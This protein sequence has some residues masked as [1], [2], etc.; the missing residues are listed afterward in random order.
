MSLKRSSFASLVVLMFLISVI[1]SGFAYKGYQLSRG[2]VEDFTL[3]D[4]HGE[5]FNLSDTRGDVVIAAFIF[6]RCPDVCP[7]ITQSLRGVQEQL[8]DDYQE[9]VSTI[10]ITVDPEYDTPERLNEFTELHGVNWSH[11]TGTLEVMEPIW[12]SFGITVQKAVIEAH[13]GD[14]NGHQADDSTVM[15]VNKSGVATE[16]MNLPTAYST[17]KFA[18][19]EANW[20]VNFSITT[21]QTYIHGINGVDLIWEDCSCE[22]EVKIFNSTSNIWEDTKLEL[23]SIEHPIG[24]NIAIVASNADD[25][26]LSTPDLKNQSVSVIYP[27]NTTDFQ[28]ISNNTGWYLSTGALDGAGINHSIE[29]TEQGYLMNSIGH[30]DPTE[31]NNSWEWQLHEWNATS[32]QWQTSQV[33]M[34]SIIS[35]SYLA[36]APNST[37]TSEIPMPG[38][39]SESEDQVCDGHGWEMGNGAGKHC[40]CDEGYEWP[41]DTMLS[42]VEADVEEEYNVGHSTT[43]LILDTQLR[44]VVAWTGDGWNIEEFVGDVE[45]VVEDE[46]LVVIDSG[47]IPGFSM[48]ASVIAISWAAITIVI[49]DRKKQD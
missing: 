21:N 49:K 4:Q 23:S 48:L 1:P 47:G 32:M 42:C 22:W 44:P 31:D 20:D 2:P 18:A 16:L 15:L 9:Y 19:L 5:E 35:P 17:L 12:A 30:E 8:G 29:Q 11:L 40:M 6:T 13:I 27:D 41:E 26:L 37:L 33:G 3:T 10:S 36:W 38:V 39:Y 45:Q 14:I 34:D 28:S 43:T 25:S 24:N 7:I 46:G